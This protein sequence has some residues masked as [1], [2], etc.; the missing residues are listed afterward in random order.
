M[1][2]VLITTTYQSNP[3]TEGPVG[4]SNTLVPC[5]NLEE[6]EAVVRA[7][8]NV[9]NG[10]NAAPNG[11]AHDAIILGGSVVT[12]LPD[13]TVHIQ[14]TS[15]HSVPVPRVWQMPEGASL[16]FNIKALDEVFEG[17]RPVVSREPTVGKWYAGVD[18]SQPLKVYGATARYEGEGRW[19]LGTGA[20]ID[21]YQYD[22]LQEL[23]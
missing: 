5:V 21:L 18:T 3:D 4:V 1:H 11:V 6:A 19:Y 22:Y 15:R 13:G 8:W 7:V 2:H 23:V 14:A 10:G 9:R 20:R 17:V 12:D 16:V